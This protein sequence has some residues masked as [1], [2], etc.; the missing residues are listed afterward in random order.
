MSTCCKSRYPNI[1]VSCWPP[2]ILVNMSRFQQ[3][4]FREVLEMNELLTDCQYVFHQGQSTCDATY[5]LMEDL[6]ASFNASKPTTLKCYL[7]K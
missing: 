1:R 6:Y 4:K 3:N 7:R 5:C 2:G